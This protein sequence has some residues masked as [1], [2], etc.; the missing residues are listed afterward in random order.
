MPI[1]SLPTPALILLIAPSGA[2]KSTFAARHFSP[3][4]IISS[5][6]CRAFIS[7]DENNQQVTQAAFGLLHHWTRLRLAQPRLTVIDATNVQYS[8]RQ[9]LLRMARAA[10]VPA[11]A[12]VLD[13]SLAT[14]LSRNRQRSQRVVAEEIIRQQYHEFTSALLHLSREGYAQIRRLKEDTLD[15]I[16]ILREQ[17][18][19]EQITDEQAV[20]E[21]LETRKN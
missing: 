12:L 3:T 1:L 21:A 8:A 15:S 17:I 11:I 13:V 6:R 5:D 9:P 18:T 20:R 10:Q 2:G 4:E 16:Q 19:R 7:D 14:C